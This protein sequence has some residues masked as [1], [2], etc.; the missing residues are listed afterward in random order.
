MVDCL[1]AHLE[2]LDKWAGYRDVTD[3]VLVLEQSTDYGED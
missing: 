3:L 1:A 2:R